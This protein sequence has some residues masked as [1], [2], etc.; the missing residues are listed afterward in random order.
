MNDLLLQDFHDIALEKWKVLGDEEQCQKW[1][2]FTLEECD[3]RY[4]SHIYNLGVIVSIAL[5]P[6]SCS[7]NLL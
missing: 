5:S 7:I 4:V 2:Q 3:I 1:L 6:V